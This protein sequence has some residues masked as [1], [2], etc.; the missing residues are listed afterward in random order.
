MRR[1]NTALLLGIFLLLSLAQAR[2]QRQMEYLDRGVVAVQTGSYS[3]FVS[4]RLLG[5]EPAETAFNL[6]RKTGK[7]KPVKLNKKPIT[8]RTNYIDTGAD[9]NLNPAYIVRPVLNGK[10]GGASE[11]AAVW[12]TKLP[13]CSAANAGW[14]FS[15]RCLSR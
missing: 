15:E 1:I 3:V 12:A 6:Y 8:E 7:K 4:W 5:T 9:L 2:A 10:E 14:V 13:D 11:A